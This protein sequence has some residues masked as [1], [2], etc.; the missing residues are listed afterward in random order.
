MPWNGRNFPVMGPSSY[1]IR[2]QST[3]LNSVCI[4]NKMSK[5]FIPWIGDR[6]TSDQEC[7]IAGW[8]CSSSGINRRISMLATW[9]RSQLKSCGN[10][11]GHSE[12]GAGFLQ[13]LR[14]LLPILI[15]PNS[16]YS[17]IIQ[18][19]CNRHVSGRCTEWIPSEEIESKI[20]RNITHKTR[21]KYWVHYANAAILFGRYSSS[22]LMNF[23]FQMVLFTINF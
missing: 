14:V 6:C 2:G 21:T 9:V 20:W 11:G 13:I 10:C 17:S 1:I 16:P 15:Q 19:E 8:P 22:A 7:N 4:A 3:R 18:L 23:P 12:T 5:L